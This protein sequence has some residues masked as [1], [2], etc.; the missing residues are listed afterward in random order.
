MDKDLEEW[1][2]D[3]CNIQPGVGGPGFMYEMLACLLAR[4]ASRTKVASCTVKFD[5]NP[6]ILIVYLYV[7]NPRFFHQSSSKMH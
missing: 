3:V 7:V 2:W 6:N 4:V 1:E 5:Q